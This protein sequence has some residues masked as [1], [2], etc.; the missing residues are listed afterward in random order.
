[1]SYISNMHRSWFT[2]AVVSLAMTMV[3]CSG[4]NVQQPPK[5]V[6]AESAQASKKKQ[7]QQR[8]HIVAP[9]PAYGNRVVMAKHAHDPD[10]G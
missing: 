7:K 10:P 9:P 2:I 4:L 6:Q 8:P 3:G 1:M 5:S